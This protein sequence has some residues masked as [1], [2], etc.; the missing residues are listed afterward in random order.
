M[1]SINLIDIAVLNIKSVDYVVLLAEYEKWGP[2]LNA[3][4]WF[5]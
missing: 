1:M 4:Y 2:K 5:D 3:K